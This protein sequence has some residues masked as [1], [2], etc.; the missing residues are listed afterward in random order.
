MF[1]QN[2]RDEESARFLQDPDV[3][4]LLSTCKPLSAVVSS[5]YQ[6]VFYVGGEVFDSTDLIV[7]G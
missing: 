4:N 1:Q 6:A 7:D 5:D 3:I 2:L